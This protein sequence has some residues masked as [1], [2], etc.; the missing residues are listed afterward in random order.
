MQP[1]SY[2]TLRN[3][4]RRER[5]VLNDLISDKRVREIYTNVHEIQFQFLDW[6]FVGLFKIT[7]DN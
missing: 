4:R 3:S 6:R 5:Y 1:E 7:F 2:I